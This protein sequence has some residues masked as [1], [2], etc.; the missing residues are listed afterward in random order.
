MTDTLLS[1]IADLSDLE[2]NERGEMYVLDRTPAAPG[3]RVFR[4]ADGVELTKQPL[5][6]GLPP[7][8]V[9]FLR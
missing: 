3:V 8:Q 2:L 4:A 7:F 1:G 5:D 9:V 6:V